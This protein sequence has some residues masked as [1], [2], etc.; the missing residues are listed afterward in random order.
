MSFGWLSQDS[1]GPRGKKDTPHIPFIS[2]MCILTSLC[3][4]SSGLKG[5]QISRKSNGSAESV[6]KTGIETPC[7][8]QAEWGT[9]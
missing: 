6:L 8:L 3:S 9:C 1:R 7:V 4:F 5:Q 2:R